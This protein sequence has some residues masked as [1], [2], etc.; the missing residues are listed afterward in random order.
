MKRLLFV[1]FIC[2]LL[3]VGVSTPSRARRDGDAGRA[4]QSQSSQSSASSA[5]SSA[6]AG[7]ANAS[8]AKAGTIRQPQNEQQ[9]ADANS[10]E[11]GKEMNSSRLPQAPPTSLRVEEEGEESDEPLSDI[12]PET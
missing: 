2:S 7:D 4:V 1:L 5:I 10:A 11:A 3:L 9:A 12:D 8:P 6:Q